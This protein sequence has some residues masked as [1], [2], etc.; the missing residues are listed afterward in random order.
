M[1]YYAYYLEL[2]G[3]MFGVG[4]ERI[5]QIKENALKKLKRKFGE[6]IKRLIE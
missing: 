2:I 3:D 1:M 4:S 5:R 6:K